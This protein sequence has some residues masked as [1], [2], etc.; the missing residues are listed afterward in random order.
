MSTSLDRGKACVRCRG[1]K[2]KCDGIRPTCGQCVRA[3]ETECEYTD[4]G[5]APSQI[6]DRKV[7]AL[8]ARIRQLDE[9][10]S[11]SVTL[12][13]PYPRDNS[14]SRRASP[15]DGGRSHQAS[16]ALLHSF[17]DHA[18]AFGFFLHRHRFIDDLARRGTTA[19]LPL[20]LVHAAQLVGLL[21]VQ[22]QNL[23]MQ[24]AQIYNRATQ[25]RSHAMSNVDPTTVL[26]LLQAE[27]LLAN[28]FL[29]KGNDINATQH[30]TAASSI[31]VTCSL[32]KIQ[33]HAR[34]QGSA[35]GGP[36]AQYQLLP[37]VDAVEQGERI[38]AF[39][40][41]FSLDSCLSERLRIPES[42]LVRDSIT[43]QTV[44]P[45]PL[46]MKDYERG[47]IPPPAGGNAL[48]TIRALMENP[49]AI[50]ENN[51][52]SLA[53][54]AKVSVLYEKAVVLV[55][56]GP[57]AQYATAAASL[58]AQI[59][60]IKRYIPSLPSNAP[61]TSEEIDHV[62]S[63]LIVDALVHC[64][65]I[66]ICTPQRLHFDLV[67]S[68]AILAAN[69][70]AN[71]LRYSTNTPYPVIQLL[72]H[73]EPLQIILWAKVA[74]ILV[75]GIRGARHVARSRGQPTLSIPGI[76]TARNSFQS[77]GDALNTLRASN[78]SVLLDREF[79]GLHA[80]RN[81]IFKND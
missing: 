23:R 65:I 29:Y 11:A 27:V 24:E 70:V 74:A 79:Q 14:Q 8:E 49:A 46:A 61:T 20:V 5:P 22:D 32:Y 9:Q 45:W 30:I 78:A 4:A 75:D 33:P 58:L 51:R 44:T 69:A 81:E 34:T 36:N 31:A 18:E 56:Q 16:L 1:R 35:V 7:A 28:Y 71:K 12:H 55:K 3:H 42:V 48:W 76:G 68:H 43:G 52:C 54:R 47:E 80:V 19:G 41:I 25:W 62:R 40:T 59:E 6:L 63:I 17:L 66:T 60:H 64:S 67:G 73:V 13:N 50:G 26:Y 2:M 21:F 39:W 37:A 15:A 77:I 38:N 57:N 53:V 72:G 10:N